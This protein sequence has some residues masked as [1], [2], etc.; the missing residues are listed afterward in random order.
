[1]EDNLLSLNS[2]ASLTYA[3]GKK[4]Y[5]GDHYQNGEGWAAPNLPSTDPLY[6]Q[7]QRNIRNIFCSKNVIAEVVDNSLTAILG[8]NLSFEITPPDDD[9]KNIA[10][11]D[12]ANAALTEWWKDGGLD[13]ILEI[14]GVEMKFATRGILRM[15]VPARFINQPMARDLAEALS[16][17]FCHAPLA[18]QA[19]V[20]PHP[21]PMSAKVGIYTYN[22]DYG[23]RH[24]EKTYLDEQGLTVI[25]ISSHEANKAVPTSAITTEISTRLPLGGLLLIHKL[26][27]RRPFITQQLIELQKTINLAITMGKQN[28]IRGYSELY[29]LNVELP[30]ELDPDTLK[31]KI[32]PI[33]GQPKILPMATGPGTRNALVG[34]I[35]EN[36]NDGTYSIANPSIQRFEPIA[37]DV[38]QNSEEWYYEMM[39]AQCRQTHLLLTAKATVSEE[40]RKQSLHTFV[41]SLSSDITQFKLATRWVLRV[42]LNLAAILQGEPGKYEKLKVSVTI[43]PNTGPLSADEKTQLREDYKLSGISL[44]GWLRERGYDDNEAVVEMQRITDEMTEKFQREQAAMAASFVGEAQQVTQ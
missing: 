9:P 23:G 12:E 36:K 30:V 6:H 15:V 22:D 42:A 17:I 38:Y 31:P 39:L 7:T 14:A 44:Y 25:E 35:L 20:A 11:A 41:S 28:I 37:I 26:Q 16:R 21:T 29:F 4:Y 1:M 2:Q 10:L 24:T 18:T 5:E 40:S 13:E 43:K 27:V 8:D 32:D 3:T 33:T 34:K 19:N